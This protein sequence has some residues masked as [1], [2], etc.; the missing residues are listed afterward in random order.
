MRMFNVVEMRR[1]MARSRPV[2]VGS[3]A[4]DHSRPARKY[5]RNGYQIGE[6]LRTAWAGETGGG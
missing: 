5:G 1:D 3:T 6:E 2:G 4:K